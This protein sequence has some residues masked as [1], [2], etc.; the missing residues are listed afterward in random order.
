MNIKLSDPDAAQSMADTLF[1]DNVTGQNR[2]NTHPW[3]GF[4]EGDTRL[5]RSV[6]CSF[7]NQCDSTGTPQRKPR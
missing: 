3:Q 5:L 1:T 7:S 6:I 4:I 2:V